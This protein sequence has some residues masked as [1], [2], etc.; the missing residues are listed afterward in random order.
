MVYLVRRVVPDTE[1]EEVT[2]A[3]AGRIARNSPAVLRLVKRAL[4]AG[5]GRTREEAM[6]LAGRLYLDEVMATR[7]ALEGLEAFME[8]R[9]PEWAGR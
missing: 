6:E 5:E 4:R 7:D 9:V 2:M 3:L 8:K 1:L